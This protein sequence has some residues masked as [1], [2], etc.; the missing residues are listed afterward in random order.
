[1]KISHSTLILICV[2]SIHVAK[3][4]AKTPLCCRNE[5]ISLSPYYY[6]P[7]CENGQTPNLPCNS[8]VIDYLNYGNGNFSIETDDYGNE[9]YVDTYRT[10]HS[11]K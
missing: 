10:V 5:S 4:S 8:S 7:E 6:S 1:M 2:I 11:P 3:A 9:M